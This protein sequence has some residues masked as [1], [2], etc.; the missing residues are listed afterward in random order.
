MS[1]LTAVDILVEPD[2]IAIGRAR[3]VNR[4]MPLS[5]AAG[6]TLDDTHLPHITLLQRYLVT[7]DLDEA[8]AAVE[9]TLAAIDPASLAFHVGGISY[10]EQWGPP[11][12]AVAVLGVRPN[13]QVLDLQAALVA[14]VA[15]FTGS[16]AT[17]AAFVTDPD[18]PI[19]RTTKDW[20]EAYVPDQ[21][22]ANY[23]AH[24]TVGLD[25]VDHLKAL[26]AEPFDAF[27]V[28][29]VAFAAYQLG[30]NGTARTLL[31]SWPLTPTEPAR[32]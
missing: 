27:D 23:T 31:K 1:D 26:Q 11:G 28:H 4:R 9:R 6:I 2:A 20:V 15:P 32:G 13:Q 7:A 29:P 10:S 5:F 22:G 3:E 30:N 25:T 8:Y 19:S 12:Q 17:D 16:G 24:L 21:T 14:A 18:Q